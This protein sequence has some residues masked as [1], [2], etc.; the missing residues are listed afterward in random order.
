[1]QFLAVIDWN[2]GPEIIQIGNFSLRWYPLMF[3]I[4]FSAG[5]YMVR[6]WYKKEGKNDEELDWLLLAV[7][8]GTIFGAR[9]GHYIFY[10]PQLILQNP[11]E[12]FLPI[13]LSPSEILGVKVPF[14]FVGFRGLASHGAVFGILLAI[15]FYARKFKQ[16]FM[17]V[18]DRI[19]IPTAFAGGFIRLGNF[20]NHEIVGAVADNIPWAVR[21][22]YHTDLLPRHP[23]QIYESICYFIT[24]VILYKVY[25]KREA[26]TPYGLL[27]GLFMILIFGFRFLIEFFK[28]EQNA[29]DVGVLNSIGLNIGQLLSIPM[30]LVGLYFLF[31]YAPGKGKRDMEQHL[32]KK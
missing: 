18:V 31:V 6:N 27:F 32:A 2:V 16:P 26:K 20:F 8:L 23:A 21:F 13:E 5:L 7:L 22:K 28:A 30:V 4:S 9:L 10:D 25:K 1:M 3:I 11:I 12:V 19:A 14:K 29:N 24:F 17:W 15:Y